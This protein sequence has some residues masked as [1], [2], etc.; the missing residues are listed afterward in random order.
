MCWRNWLIWFLSCVVWF[1]RLVDEV[2][3][4]EVVVFVVSEVLWICLMFEVML[5][6]LCVVRLMECVRFC[7][8]ID[9]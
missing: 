8:V 4:C 9:C 5:L 7:L 3:I 6:V 2:S 1:C